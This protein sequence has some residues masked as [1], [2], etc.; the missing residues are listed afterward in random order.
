ML[1][2]TPKNDKKS[3]KNRFFS[4]KSDTF[5]V[6]IKTQQTS[7]NTTR[8][9]NHQKTDH[10]QSDQKW[11]FL[12][13]FLTETRPVLEDPPTIHQRHL[14]TRKSPK[15]PQNAKKMPGWGCRHFLR[16][17]DFWPLTIQYVWEKKGQ[18]QVPT[19][20]KNTL[21]QTL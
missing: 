14:T 20:C 4:R 7:T 1:R 3:Q 16:F 19:F 5:Q 21:R 18:N 12:T 10:N 6:F 8:G 11:P 17:S 9:W 13:V 2:Q 15:I